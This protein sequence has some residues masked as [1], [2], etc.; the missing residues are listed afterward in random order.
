[1]C[2]H[3]VGVAGEHATNVDKLNG[4]SPIKKVQMQAVITSRPGKCGIL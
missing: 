4:E 2:S 3:L 1:M